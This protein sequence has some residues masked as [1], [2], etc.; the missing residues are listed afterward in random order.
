MS[1]AVIDNI[2]V[3]GHANNTLQ[4]VLFDADASNIT[5]HSRIGKVYA[6]NCKTGIQVG[7]NTHQFSDSRMEDLYASDC[8]TGVKFVGENTLAMDY[9]RVSAYN[10]TSIGIHFEQGGGSIS[11]LQSAASGA[12][13]YFGQVDGGN[14][15]KLARWDILSGYS[16]EGV[17]GER[18]IDSAKCTDTNPFTEQVVIN[19]FRC[20]PF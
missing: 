14:H 15:G 11:S 16:E 20:T 5:I 2:F 6:A 12:D 7:A 13:L 3:I 17:N 4:G 9:G 8:S 1:Q 10:N 19:G 18:F